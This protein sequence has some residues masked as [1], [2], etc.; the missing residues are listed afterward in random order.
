MLFNLGIDAP[1]TGCIWLQT[2][3]ELLKGG[4]RDRHF[5]VSSILLGG[6]TTFAIAGAYNTYL[7]T[8]KLFPGP[9]LYA[10]AGMRRA[11]NYISIALL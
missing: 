5:N 11:T 6:G 4:Y 8:G 7:R 3:K 10:G 1:M 2:R 9:H